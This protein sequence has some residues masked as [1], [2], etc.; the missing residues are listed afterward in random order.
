MV[1][2]ASNFFKIIGNISEIIVDFF[3]HFLGPFKWLKWTKIKIH[4]YKIPLVS[5][6][7]IKE[8]LNQLTEMAKLHSHPDQRIKQNSR[9]EINYVTS[10]ILWF[11]PNILHTTFFMY[12]NE[13]TYYYKYHIKFLG[14]KE[15]KCNFR[16]YFYFAKERDKMLNS[17]IPWTVFIISAFGETFLDLINRFA[18]MLQQRRKNFHKIKKSYFPLCTLFLI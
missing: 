1:R 4:W 16:N 10:C 6:V 5:F 9:F 7:R 17:P 12:V 13:I 2:R 11:S 8:P 15:R 3:S 14:S 18:I